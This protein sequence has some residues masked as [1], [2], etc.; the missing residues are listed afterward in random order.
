MN[1]AN[2]IYDLVKSL[3]DEQADEV[4]KFAE[5]VKKRF[6]GD[7]NSGAAT[8]D[9]YLG[10]LKDSPSFNEDPVEIQKAMRCEWD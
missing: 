8:L 10:V 5:Q 1:T 4:L 9:A 7:R 6:C 3:P 2:M